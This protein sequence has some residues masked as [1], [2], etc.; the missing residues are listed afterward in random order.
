MTFTITIPG[1]PTGKGRARHGQ[2]RTFTP[3]ATVLAEQAI[4]C[5]WQ[6]EGSPR[7]PDGPVALTVTMR[8]ERPRGHFKRDGSLTAEGERNP[9]PH[10][11]KPDVDNCIKLV[12]DALNKHA[13]GDDVQVIEAHVYRLWDDIAST[14][15]T[16]RPYRTTSVHV[17]GAKG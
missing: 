16:A 12:M 8:V 14:T 10:R 7:L 11:K 13:W 3:R 17:L 9:F 4:R 5:A 6:D 1:S 15:V 2:G